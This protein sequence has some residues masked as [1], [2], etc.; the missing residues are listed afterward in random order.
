ML[1]DGSQ[2][3]WLLNQKITRRFWL[4]AKYLMNPIDLN[5]TQEEIIVPLQMINIW[6]RPNSRW[7]LQQIS[8]H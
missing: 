1:N 6:S 7:P 3:Y 8:Q 4:L 5:E 2:T